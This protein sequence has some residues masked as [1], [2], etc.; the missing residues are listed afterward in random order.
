MSFRSLIQDMRD[1]FG[2]I[3]RHTL[4][5]RSHRSAGNASRAAVAEP[6]E[7]MDQSCWAQL[8]P[9]L[10][11]EVLVRIEASE[12][13]WPA[14]KDVV[15]CAGVCRT[16]RGIMKEAVCVPEVSGKLTFPISLKQPGPRDGTLKCFIRRNR[17]T[18]TYYL[19]I[20]LTEAL[21]DDGKFLLAARKCRKPTCTD[22]LISLDKVDMS[23]GSSTYIGKLRSNF[24]GTKFTVYDAHPPYDGAVVS[25]S[26][27]ARVVGLNQVSPRIPAGN[28]PVSHISYELNVLGSR[29]PRRMN[30]VMDSIPASAVEEGGKA[31]TQTEFPLSSLDSFPSIPFF[32]SKSARIDTTSQSSTQK[33][34]RLVLKNK[35]PRWHEQLQC[36]CLNFRGRVT[37]ASV[38]NFQ[39]VASEDNGSGNQE[40][41]KVILQ[42]GKIGKDLFTM[43][44]RY[45]ISAF[46][47]FAICLS[48][49]DTKIACE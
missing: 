6:S 13:W 41:D 18:Q 11:R 2:S 15:S 44:Y 39:L 7:A 21:A 23:K 20:G 49:F 34:D 16:W 32:R 42:F 9:E 19:Y 24:L 37:V 36:W 14:R 45:P 47:A 10:L 27:S 30:C 48:S 22:Y 31:P 3:S 4:R 5:S 1:E 33:E 28:Y 38:K 46:Q 43:D 26:R 29:G 35:S 12:S 25:K 40:N 17:T 8:P